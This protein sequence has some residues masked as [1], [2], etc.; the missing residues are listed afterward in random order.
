MRLITHLLKNS[1]KLDFKMLIPFFVT[2]VIIVLVT[3]AS[4]VSGNL[5][6][7]ES[8]DP[9]IKEFA[10]EV[11][12]Y[13]SYKKAK[14]AV[15]ATGVAQQWY[16][17]LFE[18]SDILGIADLNTITYDLNIWG[19]HSF[20]H[21]MDTK[22]LGRDYTKNTPPWEIKKGKLPTVTDIAE[23]EKQ[24]RPVTVLISDKMPLEIRDYIKVGDK[25]ELFIPA[26]IESGG[27]LN[28]KGA[29]N[30]VMLPKDTVDMDYL[31]Y[32]KGHWL[33]CTIAAVGRDG[34]GTA[35]ESIVVM[36]LNILQHLTG[37]GSKINRAGISLANTSEEELL[38]LADSVSQKYNS[39]Y[40]LRTTDMF[41][42]T[43]KNLNS[44]E[45]H[46][47]LLIYSIYFIGSLMVTCV[48]ILL[49]R[50]RRASDVQLITLGI[51]RSTL[52]MIAIIEIFIVSVLSVLAGALIPMLLSLIRSGSIVM[53]SQ[54]M[55]RFF[56][57]VPFNL[58]IT[59]IV[60]QLMLPN[61][62]QCLEALRYE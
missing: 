30:T 2:I 14:F 58:I 48:L 23:W 57:I 13:K 24:G 32:D 47:D 18:P 15:G 54:K 1:L 36:P 46:A 53:Q 31:S 28:L 43:F 55:L 42:G 62:K 40:G 3:S 7:E 8:R 49:L 56:L 16:T 10:G 45:K 4:T 26:V 61:S 44:L 35:G 39:F 5:F 41:I 59:V 37:A 60:T 22:I 6:V 51:N 25:F 11:C 12:V 29:A 27:V 21:Q 34:L 38:K 17:Q 19:K 9:A 20:L 52:A 50:N 33:S